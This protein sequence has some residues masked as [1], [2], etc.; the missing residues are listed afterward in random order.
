MEPKKSAATLE[1]EGQLIHD[2]K[3]KANRGN[4]K[5]ETANPSHGPDRK[6]S[7]DHAHA[8]NAYNMRG[9]RPKG[10]GVGHDYEKR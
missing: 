6:K 4:F 7:D 9:K 5:I 1:F 3:E 8:H 2:H 10:L